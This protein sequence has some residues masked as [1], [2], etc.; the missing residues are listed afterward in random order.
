[1]RRR[2]RPVLGAISGLLL[3]VAVALDLLVLKVRPL[4]TLGI[5]G[6]PAIG[7]MLGLVFGLVAPFGKRKRVAAPPVSDPP[8]DS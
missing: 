7:L 8:Q 1:M 6:L 4:D 3:G 5:I 2:G